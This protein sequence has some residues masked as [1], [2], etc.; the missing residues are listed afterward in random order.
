MFQIISEKKVK[1]DFSLILLKIKKNGKITFLINIWLIKHPI[2]D[3]LLWVNGQ[4]LNYSSHTVFGEEKLGI[5][6][7]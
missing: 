1:K 6:I 2:S 3:G 5:D 7:S 4:F